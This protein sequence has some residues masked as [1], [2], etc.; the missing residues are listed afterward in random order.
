MLSQ[1]AWS[2]VWW[3]LP[4]GIG[5]VV[6]GEPSRRRTRRKGVKDNRANKEVMEDKHT[7]G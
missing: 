5:V 6:F 1:V 7:D 2:K 3:W 4:F